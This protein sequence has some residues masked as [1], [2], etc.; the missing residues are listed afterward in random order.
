MSSK[1]NRQLK[2]VTELT[3]ETQ[4]EKIKAIQQ[5]TVQNTNN[6]INISTKLLQTTLQRILGHTTRLI[7][8]FAGN[9]KC[10]HNFFEYH[11]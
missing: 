7:S 11:I 6:H 5:L 1:N 9:F 3:E 2:L 4:R 10:E 8:K